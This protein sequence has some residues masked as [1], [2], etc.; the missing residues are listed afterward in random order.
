MDFTIEFNSGGNHGH[1]LKDA[2]GGFTIGY[3]LNLNYIHT[4]HS[5]LDFFGIGYNF[6][7]TRNNKFNVNIVQHIR[8]RRYIT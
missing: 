1:Q 4:P 7:V 3:L 2:L 8:N 5:Y 6:Y